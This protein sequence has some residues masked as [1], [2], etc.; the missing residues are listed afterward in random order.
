M[1]DNDKFANNGLE[2][3][4]KDC[5][6]YLNLK[7]NRYRIE[8]GEE[9][10][11]NLLTTLCNDYMSGDG[12]QPGIPFDENEDDKFD[13]KDYILSNIKLRNKFNFDIPELD[14][15]QP[16]LRDADIDSDDE[17]SK[18]ENENL[19]DRF[20]EINQNLNEAELLTNVDNDSLDQNID[21]KF[22][23]KK[24]G[25]FI[26]DDFNDSKYDRKRFDDQRFDQAFLNDDGDYKKDGIFKRKFGISSPRPINED[27][28]PVE[29]GNVHVELDENKNIKIVEP[30]A[31]GE[32]SNFAAIDSSY[33]FVYFKKSKKSTENPLNSMTFDQASAQEE[34][35]ISSKGQQ[36]SKDEI[37]ERQFL[38]KLEKE[39]KLSKGVFSNID[40]GEMKKETFSEC[41][42]F[43]FLHY[44]IKFDGVE[45]NCDCKILTVTFKVEPNDKNLNATVVAD[46]IGK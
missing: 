15:R 24:P 23:Q 1:V 26:P 43:S 37:L 9:S 2:N 17:Y 39:L 22:D 27:R 31:P 21:K 12:D 16:N 42:P 41:V 40:T 25:P 7:Y 44:L 28:K 4:L 10:Y 20:K 36:M 34:Y 11:L 29:E 6:S 13:L 14:N 3:K 18:N 33:A 35:E 38:S 8:L 19:N 46:S 5:I 30:T 45:R 32:Q